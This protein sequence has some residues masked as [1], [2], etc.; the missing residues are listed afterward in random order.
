MP[1]PLAVAAILVAFF[2]G[3]Y[4]GCVAMEDHLRRGP[5]DPDGGEW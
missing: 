2:A 3:L 1:L 5:D 4:L